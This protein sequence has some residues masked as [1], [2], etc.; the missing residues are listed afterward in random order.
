MNM[1]AIVG[2]SGS[3]K[4]TGI[5][6]IPELKIEGLSPAS[7]ALVNV[8]G[9]PLPFRGWRRGYKPIKIQK[10]PSGPPVVVEEGN[11]LTSDN[12]KQIVFC[13]EHWAKNPDIRN[14][15]IDDY[16]YV[17][18]NYFMQK[19]L[20][21]GY[22]KYNVLGKNAFDILDIA[23]KLTVDKNFIVLTH[24]EEIDGAVERFKMK[25]IGR[26]LDNKITLEGKF[27]VVLYAAQSVEKGEV[28]KFFVTNFDGIYPAKS[29]IG[30]FE[31][32]HIPNDLGYVVRKV[33]DYYNGVVEETE[34]P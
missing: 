24:S 11:Y 32:K 21:A 22:D 15:V 3:G 2:A 17:M 25:T 34:N 6:Y 13:V 1:I 7:T 14:I 30:M 10:N 20:V 29:P 16:Q 4:S 27:T 5:G 23:R 8:D 9:K 28:Q 12:A 26:L 19:A 33:N 18:G 31:E